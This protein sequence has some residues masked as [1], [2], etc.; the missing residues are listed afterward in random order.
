MSARQATRGA[1]ERGD[2]MSDES[3]GPLC[4]VIVIPSSLGHRRR[5]YGTTANVCEAIAQST[6]RLQCARRDAN[7][8]IDCDCRQRDRWARLS[9]RLGTRA[10]TISQ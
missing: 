5:L 1:A 7:R 8:A 4:A 10:C 9:R 2:T 3:I 6:V